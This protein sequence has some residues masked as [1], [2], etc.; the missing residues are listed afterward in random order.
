MKAIV[1]ERYGGPEVL[2]LREVETPI[3]GAGEV[4]V[5]VRASSLNMADVDYI[6][7]RPWATRFGTGL[8]QPRARMP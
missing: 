4:L 6:T 8:R 2:Q 7:G 5:R 1:R 3:P